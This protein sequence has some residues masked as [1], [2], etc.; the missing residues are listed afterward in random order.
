MPS[1]VAETTCSR[2]VRRAVAAAIFP[3]VQVLGGTLKPLCMFDSEILLNGEKERIR[4]P[5]RPAT[6]NATA[7]LM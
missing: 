4:Y 7:I 2:D 5:H 1:N 3:G 6:V